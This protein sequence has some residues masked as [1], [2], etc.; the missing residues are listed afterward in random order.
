MA[1]DNTDFRK[2]EYESL[3][4]EILD[5]ST[6][7][8]T[9]ITLCVPATVAL[10]TWVFKDEAQPVL[11]GRGWQPILLLLP[12]AVILP[13]AMLVKSCLG[14]TARIA[15]YVNLKYEGEQE[16]EICW[17]KDMQRW[18]R[19]TPS[20]MLRG[21][22]SVFVVLCAVCF[23]SSLNVK[24]SDAGDQWPDVAI[25][26]SSGIVVSLFVALGLAV[27]RHGM[28]RW[29]LNRRSAK[30]SFA[31]GEVESR[32]AQS[33][34]SELWRSVGRI[35]LASLALTLLALVSAALAIASTEYRMID[36][37]Y[38]ILISGAFGLSSWVLWTLMNA[39]SPKNFADCESEWRRVFNEKTPAEARSQTAT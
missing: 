10:L 24:F 34:S 2:A 4:R 26:I 16:G 6:K 39:W 31:E 36:L 37:E 35:G 25:G 33:L 5:N 27:I 22:M 9:V 20:S 17:Q 15:A 7:M 19:K 32:E 3:H 23:F 14:S 29:R 8:Y 30:S 38:G 11:V 1:A 18:R 21:L 12:L 28:K 13:S